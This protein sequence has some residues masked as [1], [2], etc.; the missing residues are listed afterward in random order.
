[1][2]SNVATRRLPAPTVTPSQAVRHVATMTRRNLYRFLR[3]PQLIAFSAIQ[4]VM[5]VLLF[6]FVF[7]GA[8]NVPGVAYIDYV[9]PGVMAQAAIFGSSMTAV[10]LTTDLQAG[11]VDRFRSLPMARSAVLAGRTFADL[12]RTFLTNSLMIGVG[13]LIGFRFHGGFLGAIGALAVMWSFTYAMSWLMACIGM[14]TKVPEVAQTAAFLPMFPL[15]FASSAFVPVGTMPDWLQVFATNQPVS[16][17]IDTVRALI[18]G[19]P[20][21][22]LIWRSVAWVTGLLL[23]FIPLAV[24]LYRR[25]GE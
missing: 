10:G 20:V 4:P 9:V 13:V 1:M 15:I 17:I 12:V 16:V 18:L 21:G 6:G 19:L 3:T 7:G 2:T 23:V 8:I 5:L 24:W 22:D 25:S 11:I 14:V